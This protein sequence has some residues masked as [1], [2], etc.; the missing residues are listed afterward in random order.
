MF[1][2]TTNTALCIRPATKPPLTYPTPATTTSMNIENDSK[3]PK[4]SAEMAPI[5]PP[6]RHPP[7][8]AIAADSMNTDSFSRTMFMPSV[9]QA[10]GLSFMAASRRP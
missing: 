2:I 5:W 4:R 3:R 9:A 10:A 6:K 1:C 8:P 7:R